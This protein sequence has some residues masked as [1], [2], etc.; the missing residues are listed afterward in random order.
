[1]GVGLRVPGAFLFYEEVMEPNVRP[2]E[3]AFQLA[4]T[5]RYVDV[6]EI[7]QQL[8]QEGYSNNQIEGRTLIRQLQEIIRVAIQGR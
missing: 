3:R 7:K 4:K 6:G 1:M 5:G 8:N 2:I